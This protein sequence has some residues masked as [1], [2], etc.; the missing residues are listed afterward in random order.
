MLKLFIGSRWL[1]LLGSE[2]V[3]GLNPLFFWAILYARFIGKLSANIFGA[4]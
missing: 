1:A 4:Y 3:E 2:R